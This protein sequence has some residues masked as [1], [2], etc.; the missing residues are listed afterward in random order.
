MEPINIRTLVVK[1]ML[2]VLDL[3]NVMLQRVSLE[4]LKRAALYGAVLTATGCS[5]LYYLIQHRIILH[6]SV[7]CPLTEAAYL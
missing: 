6:R 2:F 7:Y 3:V 4:S 1:G 5:V